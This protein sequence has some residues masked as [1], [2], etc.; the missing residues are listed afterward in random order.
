M[1]GFLQL[2]IGICLIILCSGLVNWG[3][4]YYSSRKRRDKKAKEEED[5]IVKRLEQVEQRLTEVQDVMIALSEKIDYMDGVGTKP[6]A[7]K[8]QMG[9]E[10]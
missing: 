2:A 4:K 9:T 10:S 5:L 7:Q 1:S 3:N 6:K 8:E